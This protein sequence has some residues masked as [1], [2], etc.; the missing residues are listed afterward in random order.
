MGLLIRDELVDP[1]VAFRH[2]V[3]ARRGHDLAP[4]PVE[5]ACRELR[6][7]I[8]GDETGELGVTAAAVRAHD[9]RDAPLPREAALAGRRAA[10]EVLAVVAFERSC[11]AERAEH[12][13]LD[14]PLELRRHF[15]RDEGSRSYAVPP[16]AALH[17]RSR[18][19]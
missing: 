10:A 18:S 4:E 14:R 1:A 17:L 15:L 11:R 12:F 6:I 9:V 16:E 5:A 13:L 2:F 7:V 19:M 8:V 3:P